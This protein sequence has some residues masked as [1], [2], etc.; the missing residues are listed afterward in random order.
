[1]APSSQEIESVLNWDM[2]VL[3]QLMAKIGHE[4]H[5][6]KSAPNWTFA[7]NGFSSIPSDK[8]QILRLIRRINN[9]D[10]ATALSVY[11][12]GN[13]TFILR[14]DKAEAAMSEFDAFGCTTQV[15]ADG[16]SRFSVPATA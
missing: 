8:G 12:A 5:M 3:V 16:T 9:C 2:D 14:A 15:L 11:N 13:G 6:R 1:M 10:L 4:V 7:A